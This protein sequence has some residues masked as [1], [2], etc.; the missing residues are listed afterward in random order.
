MIKSISNLLFPNVCNA[1]SAFL[2]E[3]EMEICTECRHELPLTNH[4]LEQN[5]EVFNKFY[6][7]F[8][9]QMAMSLMYFKKNSRIQQLIHRLKYEGHQEIGT[10]LANWFANDLKSIENIKNIDAIIP[11]PLHKKRLKERGYNQ[12]ASFGKTLSNK[13]NIPFN[14]NI[15][16]RNVYTKT[17]SQK[18]LLDRNN[19]TINIFD[20]TFTDEN[21]NKHYLLIDDVITTGA[22]LELCANALLKIPGTKISILTI[23]TTQG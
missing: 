17:Q 19:A 20:V 11:V 10:S 2:L 18:N 9:I 21:H 22:T 8:P 14:E 4:Y 16:V 12:I 5:N 3:Y 15:L 23:A 13:L 7:R 1:C 6:G